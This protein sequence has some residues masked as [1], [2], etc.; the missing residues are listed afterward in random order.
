MYRKSGSRCA[1]SS[2]ICP[3]VIEPPCELQESSSVYPK[4]INFIYPSDDEIKAECDAVHLASYNSVNRTTDPST[5]VFDDSF[6]SLDL[7]QIMNSSEIT[8]CKNA[9]FSLLSSET[10]SDASKIAAHSDM[11]T[12]LDESEGS[13]CVLSATIK[14]IQRPTKKV[15]MIKQSNYYNSSAHPLSHE[16]NNLSIT[17]H[18]VHNYVSFELPHTSNNLSI[19]PQV[20]SKVE[21]DS[22]I[23]DNIQTYHTN[24][25]Y[26]KIRHESNISSSFNDF[27][28]CLDLKKSSDNHDSRFTGF[29][30]GKGD[31]VT[32]TSVAS[33][34]FAR[35]L[36]DSVNTCEDNVDVVKLPDN[37]D[38][39][40]T[41]FKTG[42]GDSV[43]LTSVASRKFAR[44]LMD[45][46]NTC[47]D[48]VDVV[49]LPDNYDS[50]FTG[51]KTGKG[52]SV[53]LTSVAS[54]KFARALMDSVNTC[55][56][57]VDVVKLPDNYDSHFTGF[58]TG[59]GDSVTLSSAT[60]RKIALPLMDS[61]I[62]GDDS[63]DSEKRCESD[64]FIFPS[65]KDD[66]LISIDDS[67]KRLVP[68]HDSCCQSPLNETDLFNGY[69]FDTQFDLPFDHSQNGSQMTKVSMTLE[70]EREQS[71][72]DQN[73]LITHSQ[74]I[75]SSN[76]QILCSSAENTSLNAKLRGLLWNIRNKRNNRTETVN[77]IK[78]QCFL[79]W[80]LLLVNSTNHK[81][82]SLP[83]ILQLPKYLKFP[84]DAHYKW[85][86]QTAD[87]LY[88]LWDMK[89]IMDTNN[90]NILPVSYKFHEFTL[91][92]DKFG[93]VG[94]QEIINAFLSCSRIY[95]N[96]VPR[97]WIE[98][99]Y[100]QIIWKTGTIALLYNDLCTTL[101][102]DYCTPIHVLNE[103]HYRYD[104]E[105]EA[106]QRPTLRKVIEQDDTAARRL[107]L[108][109]SRLD[110][111]DG[112]IKKACLTDGWYQISWH[113]DPMLTT[114]ITSAK[115][116]VGSKLVTAGAELVVTNPSSSSS[117]NSRRKR[118]CSSGDAQMDQFGHLYGE[119]GAAIGVALKLHGNSTR[120]VSCCSRLGFTTK[121]PCSGAGLY[122]VPL[123]T[124]SSD[125]GI[126]SSIRVV[127]QRRYS[128]QFMETLEVPE[129]NVDESTHLTRTNSGSDEPSSKF[130]VNRRRVF[131][132]ERA[133]EVEVRKFEARRRKVIDRALDKL[134]L[135][136]PNKR[137]IQP[138]S[139]QLMA[140]GNDG[141]ALL[142]AI[143]NAPDSMEAEL[144]L[145]QMQRDAIQRYKE[146]VIHDAV[147]ESVPSRQVTP[148]LRLKVSGIHPRDIVSGYGAS[149]TLWSP[150]DEMLS[151]LKEG[152]V[153]EFYRLQVSAIRANDPFAP[154]QPCP[155]FVKPIGVNIPSGFVLSL[156]GGRNTRILT[157]G[158]IFDLKD[159]VS[160]ENIPRVYHSRVILSVS[161]V[162]Q[163]I[164]QENLFSTNSSNK[165]N[166]EVDLRCLIIAI[167]HTPLPSN[168]S[169]KSY[170]SVDPSD[171][172]RTIDAPF[173]FPSSDVDCVYA[174]DVNCKSET[175][176]SVIKFRSG[177]QALHLME[178][179]Q[180]GRILCFTDLQLRHCQMI[181][182]VPKLG[183]PSRTIPFINLHYTSASNVTSEKPTIHRSSRITSASESDPSV[184][185]YLQQVV[186]DFL[187]FRSGHE[188]D[189]QTSNSPLS[190]TKNVTTSSSTPQST[191]LSLSS[192]LRGRVHSNPVHTT[193]TK[194]TPKMSISLQNP[195]PILNLTCQSP[196]RSVPKQ[197]LPLKEQ[198]F[199]P[200][201][202]YTPTI[203]CG[204]STDNATPITTCSY[205]RTLP[206]RSASR[207]GLSRRARS[208][209][210]V[211]TLPNPS[212]AASDKKPT[213]RELKQSQVV[214]LTK[215]PP[216]IHLLLT[217]EESFTPEPK[218]KRSRNSQRSNKCDTSM[219]LS[220]NKEIS[221][222][223]QSS[224][225]ILGSPVSEKEN[226]PLS[227]I[228]KIKS[229]L[230]NPEARSNSQSVNDSLDSPDVSIADLVKTRQRRQSRLSQPTTTLSPTLHSTPITTK[231]RL[232]LK[233]ISK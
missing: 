214:E 164:T 105:I 41:G 194:T 172:S 166:R 51:F 210:S 158:N 68:V 163:I 204:Q 173:K 120:P 182:S 59:K 73:N 152:V 138:T 216:N 8:S 200:I 225:D 183:Q 76:Q 155:G 30:T 147:A 93:C 228:L 118:K 220:N 141:E 117:T 102:S 156:S 176:L 66:L 179:V 23:K 99:H 15:S 28:D 92:P 115:I 175:C 130:R 231:R 178:I 233:R 151:V 221:E 212:T 137:R 140:Y 184:I 170:S 110:I 197:N 121:Q 125:G 177:L 203:D 132:S 32:L 5:S 226:M 34:K 133:E 106:C 208:R 232:S 19:Q 123:C 37:Y 45:S 207:T 50:H 83:P 20:A 91:I 222:F 119:D 55:E 174:A 150:T 131:R 67:E 7:T 44:T 195:S 171:Y 129:Q 101:L 165:G 40:F 29:K 157:L 33:R 136:D 97:G 27:E 72:I 107:I 148:L 124:L 3:E 209:P 219:E 201:K 211:P 53:T 160:L 112:C 71:R 12:P 52:D 22:I 139:E 86:L 21:E 13:T 189:L 89:Y 46:V 181:N 31:S 17:E 90:E 185:S 127:I 65:V 109:V 43:T 80:H 122:P 69:C 54:R 62:F 215:S 70:A 9:T 82:S 229:P 161:E 227:D 77:P 47:E 111:S 230:C 1:M 95:P 126:C 87:K 57:N 38:S 79:K 162:Y 56:D 63:V 94:K 10:Y 180:V 75:T 116:C 135:N 35:T 143:L 187:Y 49:K 114:L 25:C 224:E 128:L 190:D 218:S 39:H 154:P 191:G 146:S 186:K 188:V 60:S 223:T 196:S 193:A 192:L 11:A 100:L 153:V 113:P 48:N 24:T 58:K 61:P 205:T 42:K 103:L 167:Y 108:C 149:I 36:M 16:R 2:F 81:W 78:D 168:L 198:D 4:I 98:N 199:T 85:S 104:R 88:W 217:T 26:E 84:N 213:R 64:N 144:N 96:L 169:N 206:N 159:V 145:T 14:L 18:P 6:A 202:R 134:V 142:H 74:S